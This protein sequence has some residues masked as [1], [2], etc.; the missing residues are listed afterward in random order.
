MPLEIKLRE[1]ILPLNGKV[2]TAA[3]TAQNMK[4]LKSFR[5]ICPRQS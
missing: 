2:V 5:V 1:Q 3:F 4:D